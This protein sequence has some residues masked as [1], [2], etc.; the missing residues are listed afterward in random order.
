MAHLSSFYHILRLEVAFTHFSHLHSLGTYKVG[1][2]SQY[3]ASALLARL[4]NLFLRL[5]TWPKCDGIE[6]HTPAPSLSTHWQHNSCRMKSWL[7]TSKFQTS[8]GQKTTLPYSGVFEVQTH[9]HNSW[10]SDV[11]RRRARCLGTQSKTYYIVSRLS[12]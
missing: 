7:K 4:S 6:G 2:I 5:R 9:K 11:R 1:R 3:L 12:A 8:C 10:C